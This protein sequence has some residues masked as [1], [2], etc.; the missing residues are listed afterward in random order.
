MTN[1]EPQGPYTLDV[2]AEAARQGGRPVSLATLARH[3]REGK[4]AAEKVKGSWT[5]APGDA[6]LWLID[7]LK[8]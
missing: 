4:V 8:L 2:L 3:C 1:E 5:V 6:Q 7:W